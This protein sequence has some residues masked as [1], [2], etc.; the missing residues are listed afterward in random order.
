MCHNIC[1]VL[2]CFS[3]F[4]D[5]ALFL[6]GVETETVT[7]LVNISHPT[8]LTIYGMVLLHVLLFVSC[9]RFFFSHVSKLYTY[10]AKLQPPVRGR[11]CCCTYSSPCFTCVYTYDVSIKC[12][13]H[14]PM[15]RFIFILFF[16]V[17]TA[18]H[19]HKCLYCCPYINIYIYIHCAGGDRP[20]PRGDRRSPRRGHRS[21]GDPPTLH[22][23]P[24]AGG[25]GG[26]RRRRIPGGLRDLRPTHVPRVRWEGG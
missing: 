3:F 25:Q 17:Y 6:H 4:L 23:P 10:I 5:T 11:S 14:T 20:L 7:T 26:V 24:V 19:I 13:S 15:L 16:D 12:T 21:H 9:F 18:V 2:F 8:Y 22:A 1:R